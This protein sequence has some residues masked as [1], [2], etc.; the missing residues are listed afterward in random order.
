M[1]IVNVEAQQIVIDAL[2][3]QCQNFRKN[4]LCHT[5][6][7]LKVQEGAKDGLLLSTHDRLG[8]LFASSTESTVAVFPNMSF[9]RR[10]CKQFQH[11]KFSIELVFAINAC[12]DP[13]MLALDLMTKFRTDLGFAVKASY[14]APLPIGTFRRKQAFVA[15]I[16]SITNEVVDSFDIFWECRE[17]VRFEALLPKTII[18]LPDIKKLL[19]E[20]GGPLSRKSTKKNGCV[21]VNSSG[22]SLPLGF[23]LDRKDKGSL[24]D[25]FFHFISQSREYCNDFPASVIQV[26]SGIDWNSAKGVERSILFLQ[27]FD[28]TQILDL[29]VH[30]TLCRVDF[31]F[32][33][34][35]MVIL[36]LSGVS[37][38]TLVRLFQYAEIPIPSSMTQGA[39]SLSFMTT[40][41][42]CSNLQADRRMAKIKISWGRIST[43]MSVPAQIK[44]SDLYKEGVCQEESTL[45]EKWIWETLQGTGHQKVL[46]FEEYNADWYMQFHI[47]AK[48][49]KLLPFEVS[50]QGETILVEHA[51][52]YAVLQAST[53]RPPVEETMHEHWQ[54]AAR[55]APTERKDRSNCIAH[56]ENNFASLQRVG[57]LQEVSLRLAIAKC[58][59]FHFS[60]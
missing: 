42:D 38:A 44:F 48:S 47:P 59:S 54:N 41:S 43:L 56:V 2:N 18:E 33:S 58:H 50:Y 19:E 12:S 45:V 37:S 34:P 36:D 15:Y 5:P 6:S 17:G 40:D 49:E 39:F 1:A 13:C 23:S 32:P 31:Y 16:V 4:V 25:A 10:L 14:L 27:S 11:E 26:K 8:E 57:L 9:V 3:N 24:K 51:R 29:A 20:K 55:L 52:P 22:N 21:E 28:D 60:L 7:A 30:L 46:C 53:F 35:R